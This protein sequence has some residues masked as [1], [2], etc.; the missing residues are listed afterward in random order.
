[1]SAES[2]LAELG[3]ELPEPPQPVAS[4][5]TFSRAGN[6]V[7]TSGHGPMKADGSFVT[8]RVGDDMDVE[9]ARNAARLTGLGLLATLRSNLGSLD[10]VT[11]IVKVL[12]MVNCT[13]DFTDPPLVLNGCS[14]LFVDVFG[15]A[16]RHARS[17]VGV[18]SLPANIPVEIE[19][20]AEALS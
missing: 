2:R 11:Q 5:V 10:E 9:A 16:G 20:I 15:E 12:G 19:V 6:M 3:L 7:Y 17:A 14:D 4:Y 8:G 13:P 18:A 1:M